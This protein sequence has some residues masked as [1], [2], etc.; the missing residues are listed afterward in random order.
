[1]SDK[2][3][4]L[5]HIFRRGRNKSSEAD[6]MSDSNSDNSRLKPDVSVNNG[7]DTLPPAL[8]AAQRDDRS[9]RARVPR[10]LQKK[11]SNIDNSATLAPSMPSD[12]RNK[13]PSNDTVEPTVVTE[14]RRERR[15]KQRRKPELAATTMSRKDSESAKPNAPDTTFDP[16]PHDGESCQSIKVVISND[17]DNEKNLN[18]GPACANSDSEDHESAKV[19]PM[20]TKS[21][22]V[23]MNEK[24][25]N[26]SERRNSTNSVPREI[27]KSIY[28]IPLPKGLDNRC[29]RSEASSIEARFQIPPFQCIS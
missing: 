3:P 16:D 29:A 13:S 22:P 12:Q 6:D 14:S 27:C 7:E 17:N 21:E 8:P 1:M 15:R 9:P 26:T 2:P 25:D 20:S 19:S 11:R 24:S 4:S 23:V 18:V 10:K 28:S 5:R